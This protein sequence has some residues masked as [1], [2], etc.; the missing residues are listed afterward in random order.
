MV[1]Q[2]SPLAPCFISLF[3]SN[4]LQPSV[5]AIGPQGHISQHPH[6]LV[7]NRLIS[8]RDLSR[9]QKKIKFFQECQE[10]S[11]I[12][13]SNILQQRKLALWPTSLTISHRLILW[14]ITSLSAHIRALN[15]SLL[16]E[17]FSLI[18]FQATLQGDADRYT[19]RRAVTSLKEMGH[20]LYHPCTCPPVFFSSVMLEPIHAKWFFLLCNIPHMGH[21]Y[22]TL[23]A[24]K[25]CTLEKLSVNA[26]VKSFER[27]R[28]HLSKIVSL[29]ASDLLYSTVVMDVCGGQAWFQAGQYD[30]HRIT[31]L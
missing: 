10:I 25:I 23:L 17:H 6:N 29:S 2:Q 16:W 12:T 1:L 5:W 7:L 19:R 8:K 9:W 20:F 22:G 15:M 4:C 13:V 18:L 24:P 11:A 21:W 3:H 26:H 27:I 31:Y 28:K 14:L 30:L